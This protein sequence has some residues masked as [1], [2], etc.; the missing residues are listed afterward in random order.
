MREAL[1]AS[2][3]VAVAVSTACFPLS[4]T[5][6][7]LRT[8]EGWTCG[9]TLKGHWGIRDQRKLLT[10]VGLDRIASGPVTEADVVGR[11]AEM[12]KPALGTTSLDRRL[13]ELKDNDVLPASWFGKQFDGALA[14]AGLAVHVTEVRWHSPDAEADE[15][16][17]RE[18]EEARRKRRA[19][20]E[21][22]K[23][24]AGVAAIRAEGDAK[25]AIAECEVNR[26]RALVEQERAKVRR[27]EAEAERAHALQAAETA[28]HQADAAKSDAE[29]EFW[30]R[31]TVAADAEKRGWEEWL[32]RLTAQDERTAAAMEDIRKQWA[33]STELLQRVCTERESLVAERRQAEQ[34]WAEVQQAERRQIESKLTELKQAEQDR[35]KAPIALEVRWRAFEAPSSSEGASA[36]R[37]K[38]TP[39]DAFERLESGDTL[40]VQ[41]KPAEDVY[42]YIFAV[43]PYAD[44]E[45][46]VAYE[47]RTLFGSACHNDLDY[48]LWR[49]E[50]NLARAGRE[51][52]LPTDAADETDFAAHA[53]AL[54]LDG[55]GLE[56]LFLMA[57]RRPLRDEE[58]QRLMF[59]IPP[60]PVVTTRG[61]GNYEKKGADLPHPPP[62]RLGA[63]FQGVVRQVLGSEAAV[64]GLA[65]V[66]L[67]I[68]TQQ[69]PSP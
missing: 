52:C 63:G 53:W 64:F 27:E 39:L 3:A 50:G 38:K 37:L 22:A 17:R 29:R 55:G 10:D 15:A 34:V 31:K 68:A 33:A 9:V 6:G 40:D 24:L 43:G 1:A 16:F 54:N 28:R 61:F 21:E 36:P 65:I 30:A 67:P 32:T 62:P 58:I 11:I 57:S 46:R 5:V 51:I 48:P 66:H 4:L 44:A 59:P 2:S 18:E 14:H 25:Q 60:R 26:W 42:L 45:G 20:A 8:K 23:H 35:A 47:W 19:E 69:E 7:D 41:V 13:S 56:Q 49:P 12:L